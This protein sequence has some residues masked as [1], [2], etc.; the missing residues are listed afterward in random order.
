MGLFTFLVLSVLIVGGFTGIILYIYFN[1]PTLTSIQ[2]SAGTGTTTVSPST[3]ASIPFTTVVSTKGGLEY[4]SL[5]NRLK[6]PVTGYYAFSLQVA[7]SATTTYPISANYN[8]KILSP[9]SNTSSTTLYGTVDAKSAAQISSSTSII[10]L[11]SGTY[12]FETVSVGGLSFLNDGS[13]SITVNLENTIAS[14][15]LI[16]TPR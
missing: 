5:S 7:V 13:Q 10:Y 3:T 6:I 8:L 2:V 12:S 4:S 14:L 9:L 11:T 1:T 15:S 16:S